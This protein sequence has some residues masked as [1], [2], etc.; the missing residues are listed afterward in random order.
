MSKKET[1]LKSQKENHITLKHDNNIVD[2]V[3]SFNNQAN[4]FVLLCPQ[5][6]KVNLVLQTHKSNHLNVMV[7]LVSSNAII[8]RKNNNF[9]DKNQ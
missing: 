8:E 4:N 6:P 7:L 2:T 9:C 5:Q 3:N 1:G